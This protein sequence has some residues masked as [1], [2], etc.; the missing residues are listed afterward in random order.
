V[1]FILGGITLFYIAN[2]Y[3][4]IEVAGAV[5]KANDTT[6]AMPVNDYVSGYMGS[7]ILDYPTSNYLDTIFETYPQIQK[8]RVQCNPDGRVTFDYDLKKPVVLISLDIVYGL[9]A[10]GELVPAGDNDMPI[11]TGVKASGYHLYRPLDE[12][13]IGY[14]LKI[15]ELL[16]GNA[17]GI[18]RK[19]SVIDV[20]D[21]SGLAVYI[22]GC[23][24]ELILGRGDE[25]LKFRKIAVMQDFL[26][27]LGDEIK[28]VDF[29]FKNQLILRK[30]N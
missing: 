23:K 15:A 1:L 4:I 14:S 19:I 11:I 22:E 29:R 17:D 30:N 6:L 27:S 24:S 28:S 18:G 5:C 7:S 2:H 10:R 3:G 20:G 9:T 13:R 21:P 8:A 16:K 12:S 26:S 25:A